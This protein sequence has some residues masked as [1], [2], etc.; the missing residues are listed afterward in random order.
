MSNTTST[1]T[2]YEEIFQAKFISDHFDQFAGL[3]DKLVQMDYNFLGWT[4]S[5]P[6]WKFW[7]FDFSAG[8]WAVIGLF[9]IPIISTGLSYLSIYISQKMNLTTTTMNAQQQST[10][11]TMLLIMPL[12]SL[13]IG[14]HHAGGNGPL[15]DHEQRSRRHS[16]R[17]ADE[18]L[19]K[20]DGPGGRGAPERERAGRKNSSA[21]ARRQNACAR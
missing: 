18:D 2:F 20:A 5:T 19:Q 11:K 21:S 6:N 16:R 13:W 15:L 12:M 8:A 3:S 4:P 17:G 14:F 1:N 10:N 9:L 7:T